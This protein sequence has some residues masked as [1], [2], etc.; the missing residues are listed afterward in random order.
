MSR[1]EVHQQPHGRRRQPLHSPSETHGHPSTAS[2]TA[3][4][5][6][7][8]SQ[9]QPRDALPLCPQH[10]HTRTSH[11][12]S[13]SLSQTLFAFTPFPCLTTHARISGAPLIKHGIRGWTLLSTWRRPR[14]TVFRL[15]DCS[16]TV[17][18]SVAVGR[19][20]HDCA[21]ELRCSFA[22]HTPLS[23]G[24]LSQAHGSA[25]G[26]S[27]PS[28]STILPRR[29]IRS[30]GPR[31]P[32]WTLRTLTLVQCRPV[33][34]APSSVLLALCRSTLSPF[35]SLTRRA[36]S[37]PSALRL[38]PPLPPEPCRCTSYRHTTPVAPMREHQMRRDL[39]C[40]KPVA[41]M[42][43]GR[44]R[45]ATMI[46]RDASPSPNRERLCFPCRASHSP[47]SM[48]QSHL[49][50]Q[51]SHALLVPSLRAPVESRPS[52]QERHTD[53][54][55]SFWPFPCSVPPRSGRSRATHLGE[56]LHLH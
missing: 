1:Q 5:P 40:S 43:E 48:D 7:S 38:C 23:S 10:L 51:R 20:G 42:R 44:L 32:D 9:P 37:L 41:P 14:N 18:E 47:S 13:C 21:H 33:G 3:P 17:L 2:F 16:S 53:G 28:S 34:N 54:P 36:T 4:S 35:S 30:K 8:N 11:S 29:R 46:A 19:C 49:L 45:Y 25:Q 52:S 39:W 6:N 31:T 26:T 22:G 56:R 50:P 15:A 55:G 24:C 27:T 12:V